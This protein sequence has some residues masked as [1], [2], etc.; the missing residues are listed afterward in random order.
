MRASPGCVGLAAVQLGVAA[1]VFVADVSNH[2]KTHTCH[3]LI[4]LCN[5]VVVTASQ[6]KVA[7]D[8]GQGAAAR[9]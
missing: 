5:A 4:V 6:W 1:N 7:R 9:D 2:P 8:R 3:G